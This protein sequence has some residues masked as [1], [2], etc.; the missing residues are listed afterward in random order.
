VEEEEEE[1]CHYYS[2][3]IN[4][5]PTDNTWRIWSFGSVFSWR[6]IAAENLGITSIK[7]KI[8]GILI[9]IFIATLSGMVNLNALEILIDMLKALFTAIETIN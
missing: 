5:T 4:F 3:S 6:R 1:L 7:K 9:S 8:A 2:I